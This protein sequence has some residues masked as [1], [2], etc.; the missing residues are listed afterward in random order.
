ML[1]H[2]YKIEPS[3]QQILQ[4]QERIKGN[5]FRISVFE[6]KNTELRNL[7]L[8]NGKKKNQNFLFL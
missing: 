3:K 7:L 8:K 6:Q 5:N 2:N 4:I 1:I